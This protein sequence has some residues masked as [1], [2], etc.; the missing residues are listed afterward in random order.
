MDEAATTREFMEPGGSGK[1]PGRVDG[2]ERTLSAVS[3]A[4]Q[5]H[6]DPGPNSSQEAPS[7][8]STI[9]ILPIGLGRLPIQCVPDRL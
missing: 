8:P 7:R 5:S 6:H 9:G 3:L 2:W 4:Q 1:G